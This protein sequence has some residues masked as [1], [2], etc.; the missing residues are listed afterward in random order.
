VVVLAGVL[1]VV[2]MDAMLVSGGSILGF[3]LGV[4]IPLT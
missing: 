1:V 2:A 4:Q 3:L